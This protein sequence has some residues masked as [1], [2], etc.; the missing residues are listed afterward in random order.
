VTRRAAA[1]VFF[2]A[3]F[4]SGC[5]TPRT[6]RPPT[7][8]VSAPGGGLY[9][10]VERGQTLYRIAKTYG[11]TVQ[12]L[13]R[14][15]SIRDAGQLEVGQRVFVPR[16]GGAPVIPVIHA[17][18]SGVG[19]SIERLQRKVGPRY[20]YS[21]WRTIT[22]HHSA[23]RQGGAKSF[24][25]DHLRRHMGGLFYHFVIGNGSSTRDGEVE[26]GFRWKRQIKANRPLDIQ[27]CLVGDFS[28]RPP[29]EAQ[30][31]STVNLVKILSAHYG[32][33]ADGVRRHT[34]IRGKHTECPGRFFPFQ[35]LVSRVSE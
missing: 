17:P 28:K 35:R 18:S 33:P 14:L 7:A 5:A 4:A 8:P 31:E 24:H 20:S 15:N 23:T 9:H 6:A 3:L 2:L 16:A 13:K 30:F 11:V 21:R 29:S 27:I 22:V 25:R 26:V 19:E 1:A 12:D 10:T 32:I 34:D